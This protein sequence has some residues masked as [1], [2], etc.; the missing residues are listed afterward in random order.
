MEQ[1]N[2]LIE[3][4][5]RRHLNVS[6]EEFE[7]LTHPC[8]EHLHDPLYYK[9][10]REM[11]MYLRK[12]KEKQR[13][14]PRLL[15]AVDGDY[16][17]D[18]VCGAVILT[19]ALSVFG[20]RFRVYIPSMNEGYGL[21][22]AAVNK[23]KQ[24]F[25]TG[26][27]YIGAI[28][29]ADNGINA[30][31]G[32]RYARSLGIDVLVTDHHPAPGKLPDANILVDPG[33]ADDLYPFKGNSGACVAWKA[34]LAY[35]EMFEKEK[36]PLIEKLIV[37]AGISNVA[38]AM[39]IRNE[40][41]YMV[42]AAVE[43]LSRIRS[44]LNYK[45]TVRT[46]YPEYNAVFHGLYDLFHMLQNKKDENRI[47]QKKKPTPLPENEELISW[48]IASL[49]NAPRRVHDTCME[50]LSVFLVSDDTVRARV[51]TRLLELN[52]EKSKLR[53]TVL[54]ALEKK[55]KPPV[56]CINTKKG[57]SGLIAG[58]LAEETGLPSIVFSHYDPENPD[59]VYEEV[60]DVERL[61]GSA[62]SNEFCPL[63]QLLIWINERRPGMVSGGGHKTAAGFSISSRNLKEF[64]SLVE[65]AIPI[66]CEKMTQVAEI[67]T[68]P[69]NI[70]TLYVKGQ[71]VQAEYQVK[72]AEGIELRTDTINTE[73]LSHDVMESVAFLETL[74]PYGQGFMEETKIRLVIPGRE[75]YRFNWN[76]DFWKTFKFHLYGVE[77]LTFDIPWADKVKQELER[78]N[79]VSGIGTL[80]INE[81]RGRKTPQL[82]LAEK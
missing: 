35:A 8:P 76:P 17:T 40:N 24:Q 58:K 73:T 41:R 78:G 36:K 27:D 81:F 7:Y 16:D 56:L 28:L 66:I 38:D 74:R 47:K 12:L 2:T 6:P 75:I 71:E 37:F 54:N 64:A 18:G 68:V 15:L 62:R 42:K 23:M 25:E 32:I 3:K 69:E 33:R 57:I 50:A 67:E 65:E 39:P 49:L 20:F 22:P 60:P 5:V 55:P 51:I 70:I 43:E 14:D 45:E 82:L 10:M 31:S 72:T 61:S 63:D 77:V 29:T 44:T 53:D 80:K 11:V 21:N 79:A 19:A 59:A 13:Q 48:Y 26:E 4:Q 9:D 52:D 34:M 46:P 1:L 30:F